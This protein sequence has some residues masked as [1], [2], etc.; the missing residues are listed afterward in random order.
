MR[1]R[2]REA[3]AC[4]VEFCAQPGVRSMA[5][6]AGRR[7]AGGD[8]VRVSCGLKVVRVARVALG[9]KPL[10]LSSG[11]AFVARFAVNS[12][13]RTDQRKAIL[14]VAYRLHGDG[15]TLNRVTR[16]A[17]GAE[18]PAVNIRMAV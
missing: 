16:F 3:E 9:R 5:S 15:P 17:I 7:E 13:M 2:E 4:V 12:R 14:M 18:L 1:I 10:K 8:M 11:C 6:F